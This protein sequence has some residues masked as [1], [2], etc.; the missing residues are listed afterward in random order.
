MG[1]VG[2][3]C[4]CDL[5]YLLSSVNFKAIS[6]AYTEISMAKMNSLPAS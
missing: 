3:N 1:A 4:A 2:S 6:Q 5:E